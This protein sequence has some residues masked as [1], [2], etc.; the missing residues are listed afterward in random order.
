[1][2]ELASE[3]RKAGNW[4]TKKK[5]DAPRGVRRHPSG[6]WAIRYVCGAGHVHKEKV[7]PLKTDAIAGY[8]ESRQRARHENGWCPLVER[9]QAKERVRA[10]RERER[11]RVTF[12][13]YAEQ[14][15]AWAKLHHRGA[16]TEEG[17]VNAMARA[18]GDAKL[19]AIT[20]AD[21]E[22]FLDGLLAKRSRSTANRYRTTLHAMLNRAIRHG[23]LS[24][25]PVKGTTKFKEAEGRT[26]YLTPDEE[27]AV[28][29][30]LA[31]EAT[32]TG[33]SSLDTRRGD[34]R[35]LFSVSIHTGL[36][37]T[38][39]RRLLWRDV[40]FLTGL[41]AVRQSKSGHARQVPMNSVVRSLLFDLAG[42]RQRPDDPEESVFRCPYGQPRTA[43]SR[44]PWSERRKPSGMRGR[45]QA[46]ST[47]TPGTA[48][49]IRS[50]AG[51]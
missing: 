16:K 51:S 30:Q 24:A 31:P 33:R 20:S 12:R 17:R 15:I 3:T 28:R 8:Y 44:R 11:R 26:L 42:Q 50:P 45:M 4:S 14:Y 21:V 9:G 13:A 6:V 47:G 2:S 5:D 27:I 18:F 7:G 22:R 1:M 40:D 41:L 36:R 49:G 29:D 43:S 10:D 46:G 48:T 19:D 32:V 38:E 23:Y 35:P 25:N 34:L 37:W 39:Q